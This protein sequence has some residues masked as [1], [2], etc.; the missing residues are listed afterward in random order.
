MT[1]A[2]NKLPL[3]AAP[4]LRKTLVLLLELVDKPDSIRELSSC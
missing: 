2:L 3:E 1:I 4:W